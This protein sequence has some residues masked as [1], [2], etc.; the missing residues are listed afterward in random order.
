MHLL[1]ELNYLQDNLLNNILQIYKQ[2]F[3]IILQKPVQKCN[4]NKHNRITFTFPTLTCLFIG[5][6]TSDL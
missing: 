2:R 1:E 3:Y 5:Q 4:V 6:Y